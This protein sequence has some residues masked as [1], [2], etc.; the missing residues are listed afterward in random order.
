M[1]PQ[2]CIIPRLDET[3]YVVEILYHCLLFKRTVTFIETK[4]VFFTFR[5]FMQCYK[6]F[7]NRLKCKKCTYRQNSTDGRLNIHMDTQSPKLKSFLALTATLTMFYINLNILIA[8]NIYD[9]AQK[10]TQPFSF[11]I[12]V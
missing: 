11:Q 12:N 1:F 4:Y 9:K 5:Y 3:V 2:E 6:L 10:I 8:N 7:K